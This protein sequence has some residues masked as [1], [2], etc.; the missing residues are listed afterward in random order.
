LFAV[1][2]EASA[3]LSEYL[4]A[5]APFEPQESF[6]GLAPRAIQGG[7][8][9]PQSPP[10]RQASSFEE[11]FTAGLANWIGGVE[12]WKLDAAGVRTGSLALFEPSIGLGDYDL[13]FLV[14]L[15]NRGVSWV[16]R[17]ADFDN[18]HVCTLAAADDGGYEF[19][20]GAV[21]GGSAESPA[22]VPVHLTGGSKPTLT[23]RTH[24][25]GEDFE[26]SINGEPV[27]RWNDARHPEGGVGF[28]GSGPD[29]ARLY[30]VRLS[31][32]ER[33]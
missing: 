26:V 17:A 8:A 11:E 32:T 3:G 30:W 24:V 27:A 2:L 1:P 18:Y 33:L 16:F 22:V 15:E 31:L 6:F 7:M 20:R 21:I 10:A 13:E 12:D 29:R 28:I 14:R 25:S 19:A 5:T 9:G 23:V 4:L